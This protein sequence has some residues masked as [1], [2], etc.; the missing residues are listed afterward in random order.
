MLFYSARQ[1]VEGVTRLEVSIDG[2]WPNP[3]SQPPVDDAHGV[4]ID[5]H[6]S[7]NLQLHSH[8]RCRHQ[9]GMFSHCRQICQ[10]CT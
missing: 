7:H 1:D 8:T 10:C 3:A 2:C 5:P 4:A 9:F 6:P